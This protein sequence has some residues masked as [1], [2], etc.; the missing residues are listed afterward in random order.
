MFGLGGIEIL[1]VLLVGVVVL[2]P[3]RLPKVMRTFTKLMSDFR[4]V[5][6]DLQR[7]INAEINIEEYNRKQQLGITKPPAKKK[8]KKKK[9]AAPETG[10]ETP[11][12][13]SAAPT[14]SVPEE[15]SRAAPPSEPSLEPSSEPSGA[16]ETSSENT[17][18][19]EKA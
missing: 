3:E 5:S 6:T 8:K 12:A 14:P 18:S 13:A 17:E 16:P 1:V 19:G 10:G 7:T 9:A 2:G 4:R 11:P 15:P